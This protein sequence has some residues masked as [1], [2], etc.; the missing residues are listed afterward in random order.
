MAA[1][2]RSHC[3]HWQCTLWTVYVFSLWPSKTGGGDTNA[4][5][6][7]PTWPADRQLTISTDLLWQFKKKQRLFVK[8]T[9]DLTHKTHSNQIIHL[10]YTN[11]WN[12]LG[13]FYVE[14]IKHYSVA[15]VLSGW[16]T[17]FMRNDSE[18]VVST[19]SCLRRSFGA[20]EWGLF[21]M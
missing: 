20:V 17:Y 1:N 8:N 21:H 13:S 11:K 19:A 5:K 10:F 9:A 12:C 16:V 14:W 7:I 3:C 2:V 4:R 6:V 18:I 15:C